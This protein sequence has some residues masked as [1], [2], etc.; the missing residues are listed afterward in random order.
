MNVLNR[1]KLLSLAS[2]LIL[3]TS[4]DSFLTEEPTSDLT[5][6]TVVQDVT[7]LNLLLQGTYRIMRD[8]NNNPAISSPL[9]LKLLSTVTGVDMM[10]NQEQVGNNWYFHVFSNQRYEAT[11]AVPATIWTAMYKVINNANIILDNVDQIP[12]NQTEIDAIKGQALALRARCYFNLVRLYQHTYSIA[13]DKPGVPLQL[14]ADLEPK[15]RASVEEVY[16]QIVS[17]LTQATEL[18]DGYNRPSINYY[19][20]DVA[21]FLL[22]EVYLTMENWAKAQEEANSVRTAY[23][24]MTIGDYAAGFSTPNKEWVLGY[25]QGTQDYWW[26]DSPA[27]W[28]DFGQNNAPWQAEQVLPSNSFVTGIMAG[29]P[30]LLVIEN[31]LYPGKYAATKFREL[32]DE[33]PYGNLYDLRA[34]EMYLVEAEAAARQGDVGTALQVLNMLQNERGASVTTNSA[35]TALID[36]ILLERRKEMW[37]EGVEWF[38]ILRLQLPVERSITQG[39]YQNVSIPKNSN[40]LIMMIPEKEVINNTLVVQ[41]PNPDQIP[42]FVP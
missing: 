22:A 9:G 20:Q 42:V 4:C 21:H 14:T 40:K 6:T 32:R 31:P 41:N 23:A 29:D 1:I 2:A 38:D 25:E 33:P 27:C 28:F 3:T 10:V 37:G 39:H 34:A 36:A 5:N 18:L 19:N 16:M 24:L 17:D 13:K 12:G 11:S 7:G 35:Q 8:G 15:A 26:Y 30:R